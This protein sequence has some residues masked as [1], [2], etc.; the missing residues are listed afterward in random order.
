MR[1]PPSLR[2]V[3]CDTASCTCRPKART[4]ELCVMKYIWPHLGDVDEGALGAGGHHAHDV[5]GAVQGALRLLA[6]VI[7]RLVEGLVDLVLKGLQ[8]GAP[9]ARLQV[10]ALQLVRQLLHRLLR[11]QRIPQLSE[12]SVSWKSQEAVFAWAIFGVGIG[13]HTFCSLHLV[14]KGLHSMKGST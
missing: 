8:H 14:L 4:Y 10:A 3:V 1:R 9:R 2:L 5:V 11:L 6:R 13:Q 12:D 7:A